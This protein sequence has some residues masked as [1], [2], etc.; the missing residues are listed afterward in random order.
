MTIKGG[1][2]KYIDAIM[3]DFPP[4]R[5]HLNT[6]VKGVWNG[7]KGEVVVETGHGWTTAYDHVI[8]ATHG[9]QAY[10]I[11]RRTAST[12]EKSILKNFKTSAN[13]AVLH[14]DL[15]FM[16]VRRAAWTAWNYITKSGPNSTNVDEVS[17]TYCM[18]I[19]QHIPEKK[20]GNVLVTLN[21]LERPRERLIQ[22]RWQYE[23]PLY[24]P[25]AIAAQS[26]LEDIQNTR[27]ISYAGAW[28]KYGFHEDGF[29]SGLKV[30]TEHLGATLPFEF[31]DSTYSRG[32][33]P[34]LTWKDYL[35]RIFILLVQILIS[36]SVVAR[37]FVREEV[38]HLRREKKRAVNGKKIKE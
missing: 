38:L 37:G 20:F 11:T 15:D 30:A 34:K 29:S 7:R 1:S 5:I 3:K 22:G 26:R 21:P 36:L 18:N 2:Q 19:L 10:H 23:H 25:E 8:L 17:L 35:L 31:T 24:T 32:R 27:N 16:P 28:T 14:S 13:E 12:E 6:N 4:E 33:E 9:D